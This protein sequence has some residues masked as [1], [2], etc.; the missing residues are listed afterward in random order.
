M[1][2]NIKKKWKIITWY[3]HL[4][5][6]NLLSGRHCLHKFFILFIFNSKQSNKK[7]IHFFYETR[8]DLLASHEALVGVSHPIITTD[9]EVH[10]VT[11]T[12]R[13]HGSGQLCLQTLTLVCLTHRSTE[14]GASLT[15]G[16]PQSKC[17]FYILVISFWYIKVL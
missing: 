14:G 11:H 16:T 13:L 9:G 17:L 10:V 1:K 2:Q 6:W 15:V 12:H 3:I 7:K 4:Q 5:K 8:H